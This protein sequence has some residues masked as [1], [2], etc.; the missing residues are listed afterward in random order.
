MECANALAAMTA[1][2]RNQLVWLS[3]AAWQQLRARP[4]DA[5][6][7]SV[8]SHWHTAQL[9]LVVC[10][11]RVP[12]SLDTISLGL[13]APLRWERRKLALEV[14]QDAICSV[15]HFPLLQTL[16]LAPADAAHVQQLVSRVQALHVPLRVYGSY[17]WQQ[18]TGLPCVR[19]ASDLDLLAPVPDLETAG[20]VTG[21]LQALHLSCRVDGELVFPGGWAVAWREFLQL[22]DGAVDRLLVKDRNRVQLLS[23][24]DLRGLLD[25]TQHGAM[26]PT[27]KAA[28]AATT[29]ATSA[30]TSA[31]AGWVS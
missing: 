17:G 23:L 10:R 24:A 6:A 21:V 11:Q 1:L 25:Q 31:Y 28:G 22:Q 7:L 5:Q 27:R 15:G 3:D 12:E 20:A 2:Q 14:T 8:L 18:L 16:T 30:G 4:W 26:V 9:P 13:P 29:K 19:A